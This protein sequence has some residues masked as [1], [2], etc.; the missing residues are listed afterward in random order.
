MTA[1]RE[2]GVSDV[3]GAANQDYIEIPGEATLWKTAGISLQRVELP[4]RVK[5]RLSH[6]SFMGLLIYVPLS[7]F[8]LHL[9]WLIRFSENGES[10]GVIPF[11]IMSLLSSVGLLILCGSAIFLNDLVRGRTLIVVNREGIHDYRLTDNRISWNDVCEAKIDCHKGIF[12]VRLVLNHAPS[13]RYNPLRFGYFGYSWFYKPNILPIKALSIG[14]D[15]YCLAAVIA[16]LVQR[17]GG[18][19]TGNAFERIGSGSVHLWIE[20]A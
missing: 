18:R 1:Q 12:V 6:F 14:P 8:I 17:H 13:L 2:P 15:G 16:R 7:V 4:L 10:I 20:N 5:A 11:I 9:F 3:T 19:L